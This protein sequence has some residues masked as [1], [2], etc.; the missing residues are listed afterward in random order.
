MSPG[1][2]VF[3]TL[4]TCNKLS[5]IL[6]CTESLPSISQLSMCSLLKSKSTVRGSVLLQNLFFSHSYST[7]KQLSTRELGLLSRR[8]VPLSEGRVIEGK[9]HCAYHGWEF[10]GS[11][12]PVSIPQASSLSCLF[13][14]SKTYTFLVRFHACLDVCACKQHVALR[15]HT[16]CCT[17][18]SLIASWSC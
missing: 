16:I 2:L 17:P 13:T 15:M 10:N 3:L 11:G 18:L 8:M 4:P 1:V 14:T 9:L 5:T 6:T 12:K 7:V